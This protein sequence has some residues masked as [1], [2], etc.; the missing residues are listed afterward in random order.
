MKIDLLLKLDL[1]AQT[2]SFSSN[3]I[4]ALKQAVG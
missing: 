4:L 2:R 1:F 3:S